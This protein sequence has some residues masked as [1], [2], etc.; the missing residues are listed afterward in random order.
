MNN[1]ATTDDSAVQNYTAE[2]EQFLKGIA[3]S[4]IYV[5]S[6]VD[7]AEITN[8]A[9]QSGHA[10]H[11]RLRSHCCGTVCGEWEFINGEWTQN[12]DRVD[13]SYYG[14]SNIDIM[15]HLTEY[16]DN[17]TPLTPTEIEQLRLLVESRRFRFYGKG[18]DSVDNTLR[19]LMA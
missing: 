19:E 10:V 3:R 7:Y 17:D 4:L 9:P 11:F 1:I 6:E 16:S 12:F 2:W 15:A 14:D 13:D 18:N 8:L 5:A